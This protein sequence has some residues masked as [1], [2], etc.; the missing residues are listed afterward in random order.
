[1]A[2]T[3]FLLGYAFGPLLWAPLSEFFGRRWIFH[4][5]FTGYL[6]FTS[7]CAFAN[8]FAA[9]FVGRFLTGMV[10]SALLTNAPGVLA[11]LWPPIEREN[12]IAL[13]ACMNFAGPAL[14]PAVGGFLELKKSWRWGFYALVWF[15]GITEALIFT[16]RETLPAAVLP[17]RRK[18]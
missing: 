10:S 5:S 11:D 15:A 1:M 17:K 9:L 14:G 16:I 3:V 18:V 12:A 6:A 2:I 4:I 7:L 13:F 8:D